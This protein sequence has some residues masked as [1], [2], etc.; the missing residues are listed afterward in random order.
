MAPMA[1]KLE[2]GRVRP[3]IS[4]ETFFA[5]SLRDY[6]YKISYGVENNFG[7]FLKL[8]YYFALQFICTLIFVSI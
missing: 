7:M 6:N 4:G 3:T 5:A 8:R 2:G 1:I